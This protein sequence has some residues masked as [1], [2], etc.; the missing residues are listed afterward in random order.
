M[1]DPAANLPRA[2]ANRISATRP[3]MVRSVLK[4]KDHCLAS[5]QPVL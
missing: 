2:A 5:F 3:Q 1:R 4:S